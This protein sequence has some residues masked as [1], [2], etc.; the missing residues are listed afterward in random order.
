MTRRTPA[1]PYV[2]RCSAIAAA[3]ALSLVAFARP[4][5]AQNAVPYQPALSAAWAGHDAKALR[6]IDAYL[7]K[8]PDDHAAQ[9][10]RA[11]FL[12][13]SG[14]YAKADDALSK[15]GP[16]DKEA[17]ALRA[18]VLGWAGRRD[19]ALAI[20][21][22]LYA[23]DP[24]DYDNAWT[25]ALILR[26]GEWPQQA[27]PALATVQAD[28]PDDKDTND[29]AKAV[30]LPLFSSVG[31][32]PSLYSDSDHIQIRTLT[33]DT[34]LWLSDRWRFLGSV[35]RREHVA[36][37]GGPF[38]PLLGSNH[39]NEDRAGMGLRYAPSPD[40][41]MELWLGSSRT[42]NHA[43][44]D[45]S[46]IGHLLLSQRVNDD[47]RYTL[48]LDRDRD[49][50]SPR[51]LS[52]MR[53]GLAADLSWTPTL[54]DRLDTHIERDNF[55]DNNHRSSLLASYNRDVYR[56][57]KAMLDLGFQV[58]GQ[59]NSLKTNRGY[60][61]PDRYLR[62][63]ATAS[64]YFPFGQNA[65]LSVSAALGMQKDE[66]FR[67]WKP[68]TDASAELVLGIFSHWQLVGHVGYSRRLNQFG[69]YEGNNV[70]LT[71][72]YRFCSDRPTRCPSVR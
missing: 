72:R 55:D 28:K 4:A 32:S 47:F 29:L 16:E 14:A 59:H 11:R 70:G 63:A 48:K 34:K 23:A 54:R 1:A 42:D 41:A 50:S 2:P 6:L 15:F 58:E 35:S 21:A 69:Y 68:A 37:P 62:Y 17:A 13:W 66:T 43:T 3:I 7:A 51:A 52:V 40:T 65:G 9:L 26:Q 22:P 44:T 12:A 45:R 64:T 60:Y 31:L 71:L 33:L 25:Q 46:L 49:A 5:H 20:N 18:R 61:S 27:L 57:D 39:V 67:T 56:G 10:D 38:A 30:R 53:D 24:T 36:R 8:H 19:A